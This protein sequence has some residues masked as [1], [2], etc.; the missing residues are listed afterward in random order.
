MSFGQQTNPS[1]SNNANARS[2]NAY[3]KTKVLTAS[4][5]EL[6]LMLLDGA[7]KFAQQGREGLANKNF[8]ASFNGFSQCRDIIIELMTSIRPDCERD[9]AEKVKSLYSFMY[10]HLV[11]GVHEKDF[12]K[13]DEVVRLLDYERETWV[14]AMEKAASE[15]GTGG[16]PRPSVSHLAA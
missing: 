5:Q 4:P 9:L 10:K 7:I 1:A 14:L 8:E 2:A 15:T 12:K 11:E 13:I 16:T 3:L 6:R